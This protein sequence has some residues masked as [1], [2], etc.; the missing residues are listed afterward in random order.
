MKLLIGNKA[1]SSW[2]MR[3]WMVLHGFGI[4]FEEELIRL[5]QPDTAERIAAFSKAA[6]VPV[7]LHDGMTIWD[8][9]AIIEYLAETFPD[10]AIWPKAKGARAHA[11]SAV[12]EF[13][14]GF[15]PL[16]A[17]LGMNM[18]REP[19]AVTLSPE[20]SAMVPRVQEIWSEARGRYGASGRYL[21]GD[22]SAADAFF[23]PVVNRFHAYAVPVTPEVRA[24][25]DV[26]M[27]HPSWKAWQE[28][29]MAEPWFEAKYES[30][31]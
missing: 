14:S 1:Y 13:H 19:K 8:S 18:R 26:M 10:K 22:Y 30:I 20:V 29:A 23:A 7:L 11:R 16:R 27:A 15:M 4:P 17:R 21:Y 9:L 25:L 28:A 12:A 2:S 5:N 31:D 6:K 3:P 24:Y